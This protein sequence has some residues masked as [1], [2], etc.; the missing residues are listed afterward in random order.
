M[1]RIK[2]VLL[3][4]VIVVAFGLYT[5]WGMRPF[6]G[7][8]AEWIDGAEILPG[9]PVE[10]TEE[11]MQGVLVDDTERLASLLREIV[12]ECPLQQIDQELA[13]RAATYWIYFKDSTR[14]SV[15]AYDSVVIL[16]GRYWKCRN[17]PSEELNQY[18]DYL[19]KQ[20]LKE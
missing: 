14:R 6:A 2:A 13:D 9:I 12:L 20:K 11:L 16:D 15:T 3:L 7:L 4:T 17:V 10:G 8:R 5:T 18:A 1:E 19:K